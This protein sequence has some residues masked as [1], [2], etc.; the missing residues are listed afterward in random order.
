[1]DILMGVLSANTNIEKVSMAKNSRKSCVQKVEEE[2]ARNRRIHELEAE[3]DN[4]GSKT[5]RQSRKRITFLRKQMSFSTISKV[6]STFANLECLSLVDCNLGNDWAK[7]LFENIDSYA[8]LKSLNVKQNKISSFG[9]VF[10][11]T[12]LS[13]PQIKIEFL[14][15]RDNVIS[16]DSLKVLFGL[17]NGNKYLEKIEYTVTEVKNIDRKEKF[18]DDRH[19]KHGQGKL[20]LSELIH[21]YLE[22][23]HHDLKCW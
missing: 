4:D 19:N 18:L 17:L 14:D 8:N 7:S 23:S 12:A 2:I 10:L 21:K 20:S 5:D 3:L 11:C 22:D 16:D 9:L 13:N 6:A 15:I 1:M